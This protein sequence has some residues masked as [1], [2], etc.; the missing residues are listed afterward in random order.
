MND[1]INRA[2]TVIKNKVRHYS[3]SNISKNTADAYA[4]YR[5]NEQELKYLLT[6]YTFD[7]RHDVL[8]KHLQKQFG[9]IHQHKFTI[10]LFFNGIYSRSLRVLCIYVIPI[11]MALMSFVFV[12]LSDYGPGKRLVLLLAILIVLACVGTVLEHINT[13][14]MRL[15]FLKH[16]YSNNGKPDPEF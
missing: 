15:Y 4:Y 8:L 7:R 2:S 9:Q 10:P 1:R 6:A 14:Y 12:L 11:I 3:D 16:P 13:T 5:L